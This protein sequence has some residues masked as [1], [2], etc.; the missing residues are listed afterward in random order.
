MAK[1][2]HKPVICNIRSTS[3]IGFDLPFI[4]LADMINE[5]KLFPKLK[6]IFST[7]LYFQIIFINCSE[8]QLHSCAAILII[9]AAEREQRE[10]QS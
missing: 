6:V 4:E 5:F 2:G 9:R 8:M 3:L 7:L 10:G 1:E